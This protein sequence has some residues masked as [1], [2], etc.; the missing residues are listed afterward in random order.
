MTKDIRGIGVLQDPRLNKSTAFTEA[1]KQALSLIGL[2]PDVTE[3]EGMQLQRVNLQLAQ[4]PTDL[5]RYIYL[6]NLLDH[7][8]TLFYRTLM[9]D[10]ARFLPIVYD[11]TIG[12]A[13]LKFGHIYRQ[14]RGMYL[15]ITR[16]GK[17]KDVLRNWPQ[18]DVRFICVTDAGRILGLGDLGAN[19][20][21]IPIGKLQLYTA[22]AGVPPQFLLPMYLDAGTN[23][24]Q[25]L[26]DPLYLGM[27]K[28]RPSTEELYTFVDE[29]VEAVQEVFPKCCI[30]FEDWTGVDAVH[31]LQRY[32]DKYCV[33]NDDVQGTAG[34]VLAGMINAAK[35]KGKK[36]SDEKYLFLGAG[37][38]GIGLADLLCTAMV[39][40]GLTLKQAQSR[41]YMFDINGLLEDTRKDLVDFQKPYAH[42][43][44]PTR[45][46]VAAIESIK[47]T[48][49]I[50]VSTVGGTF[51]QKVIEAMSRINERPVVLALSNPTEHAE[52]T[53]E[54]AYSWSKGKA[55]YA[56]GVQFPPVRFNGQ[57]FLPGQ[58]NNFYIFP[59]VGMAIFATQA[60]R[61]TD[62][63]FIEAARAVA[64]QVPSDVLN[65]GLLYPL[66]SN[67]LET[68]IQ[69]A[70]RVAK[71]AFDLGLARV[72]RPADMVAFIR[73][74]VYKPEYKAEPTSRTTAA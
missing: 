32:R 40:E 8:E 6:M 52:C 45:D 44:A 71:L 23:N 19:G 63:M 46:F 56:A 47:P 29:F 69:T 13:C 26:H 66:Q 31:L 39:Q 38:A 10:P 59:A 73:E 12:E 20:M 62:E 35:I 51:T 68:E 48:T 60:S 55:I 49:I 70:A 2:V 67:I 50:G 5:E 18:Q 43:H 30:H 25:Y 37:S 41:V 61:V 3:T 64:D 65:Q 53:A 57:T 34:I 21:G 9:S 58:A 1:E 72:P 4:K 74:H 16:R 24:E 28:T 14:A 17:V 11:P 7:N 15:S 22:C 36:L 54:Q 33:Y 27:R 42:K